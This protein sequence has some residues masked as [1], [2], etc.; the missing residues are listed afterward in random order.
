MSTVHLDSYE[1]LVSVFLVFLSCTMHHV[2]MNNEMGAFTKKGT[3]Y[4]RWFFDIA[5]RIPLKY[6]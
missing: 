2:S 5:V 4:T 6:L 1:V 3:G